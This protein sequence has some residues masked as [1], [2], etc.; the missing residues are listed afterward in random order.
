MARNAG[1]SRAGISTRQ[2][3]IAESGLPSVD[4][5]TAHSY[6]STPIPI[7]LETLESALEWSSS[8]AP[9][10]N[11]ASLSRATGQ[12]FLKS[13]YG[14][15]E[16]QPPE[17]IEDEEIYIAVPHKNELDLGQHL[18]HA[19]ARAHAPSQIDA[20][21]ACFAQRGAYARFKRLLEQEDL[22]EHWYAYEAAATKQALKT[23]ASENGFVVEP[24][25][26]A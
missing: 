14:E 1:Y 18:A 2:H 13:A 7:T 17:D 19:F 6:M 22:L 25:T 12:L 4:V 11:E 5:T 15:L 16:E 20:I 23:W 10:E 9:F 3:G 8:G 24:N 26:D 21:K